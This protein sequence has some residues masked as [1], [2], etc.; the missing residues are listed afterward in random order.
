MSK[1]RS[2]DRGYKVGYGRP[3]E[4]HRFKPGQSGN[5]K[6]R[7]KGTRSL[8]EIVLREA[9]RLVG[10]QIGGTVRHMPR[11]E[12]VIRKLFNLSME[13]NPVAIRLLLP[14]LASAQASQAA[15]Q[16][17]DA[18]QLNLELDAE[19]VRLMVARLSG[20]PGGGRR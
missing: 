18:A 11:A 4:A 20:R 8:E 6:G 10:I 14:L 7:P 16:G 5:P 12:V 9:S 2:P 3:P 13:G 15:A 17:E 1:P 19:T